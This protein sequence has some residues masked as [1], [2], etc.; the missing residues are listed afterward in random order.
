MDWMDGRGQGKATGS[1][2]MEWETLR[3]IGDANSRRPTVGA[4]G[5]I[6]RR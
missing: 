5:E 1:H 6:A 2:R 3:Y 4:V